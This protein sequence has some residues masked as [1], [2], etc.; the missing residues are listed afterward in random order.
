MQGTLSIKNIGREIETKELFCKDG[1]HFIKL[2]EDSDKVK[3]LLN[4]S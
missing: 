2:D 3:G 1:N 4:Q